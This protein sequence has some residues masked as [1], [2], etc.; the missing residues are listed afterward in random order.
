MVKRMA[1]AEK[2]RMRQEAAARGTASLHL[3]RAPDK[4]TVLSISQR[5]AFPVS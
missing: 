4:G 2:A 5:F 1:M 3:T